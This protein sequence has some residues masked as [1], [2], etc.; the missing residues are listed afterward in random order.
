MRTYIRCTKIHPAKREC[1]KCTHLCAIRTTK[2]IDFN[3]E[4]AIEDHQEDIKDLAEI[5]EGGN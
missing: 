4:H 1:W 2:F 3:E 5:T